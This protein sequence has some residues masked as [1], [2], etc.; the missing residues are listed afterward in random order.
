MYTVKGYVNKGAF[1][2]ASKVIDSGITYRNAMLVGDI[3]KFLENPSDGNASKIIRCIY[4]LQDFDANGVYRALKGFKLPVYFGEA[5]YCLLDALRDEHKEDDKIIEAYKKYVLA[6]IMRIH[7]EIQSPEMTFNYVYNWMKGI[8][9]YKENYYETYAMVLLF[10]MDENQLNA[11]AER[12]RADKLSL[13]NVLDIERHVH[14]LVASGVDDYGKEFFRFCVYFI[15]KMI[16]YA[17]IQEMEEYKD[18]ASRKVKVIIK[19]RK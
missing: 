1:A 9:E 15:D 10:R 4:E 8:T 19:V 2:G 17:R 5:A 14:S 7:D 11:L 13:D 6:P 18:D 12:A 16:D 3:V